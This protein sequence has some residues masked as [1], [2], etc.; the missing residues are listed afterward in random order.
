[1]A[2]CDVCGEYENLPYQCR[3]C[4]QTFCAQ[5][6]LPENH[7][8]PGLQDWNDPGGVFDSG[9]D[10]TVDNRGGKSGTSSPVAGV[11]Q[12]IERDVTGTGGV[13]G[14]FRGNVT[15]TL[16]AIFWIV[17]V[18]EFIVLGFFGLSTFYA[19][20]ALS[21]SN[22]EYV[23]T[24][25]TSV[26]SHSPAGL[27]HIAGN[28]IALFFFGPIVERYVGSKKFLLFFLASGVAAGLGYVLAALLVGNSVNVLG[29][30]GAVFAILGVV[31]VLRPNLEVLLF[32]I[33]PMK[34]KVLTYGIAAI[35]LIFVIEPT[36][37]NALGV[38]NIAHLAHLIGFVIGLAY[39]KQIE[40]RPPV[41]GGGMPGIQMGRGPGPRR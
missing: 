12:R 16:L 33:I 9:F 32:F 13:L 35:S 27:L 21:T 31:T 6:R 15:Y 5:H 24:W 3:R 41:R 28:S 22:P 29:A 20:F 26:F 37:A 23:W 10:D 30:S 11:K 17:F 40:G 4:G 14:F 38:G 1:M 34:I 19:V 25:V 18:A 39:G 2:K 7:D 8:C 36:A